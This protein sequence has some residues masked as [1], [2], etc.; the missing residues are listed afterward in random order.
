MVL[1]AIRGVKSLCKTGYIHLFAISYK[2]FFWTSPL[3]TCKTN[4]I[5]KTS[6]AAYT[7]H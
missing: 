1:S 3:S 5:V 6:R 2:S 7:L 4:F